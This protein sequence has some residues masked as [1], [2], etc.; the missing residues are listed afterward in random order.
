MSLEIGGDNA[1]NQNQK[2]TNQEQGQSTRPAAPQ[3]YSFFG[4][5]RSVMPVSRASGSEVI[6]LAL[7]KL[8]E[9][10]KRPGSAINRFT[11]NLHPLDASKETSIAQL[12]FSAIIVA[13]SSKENSASP[14]SYHTLILGASGPE[15]PPIVS[16]S[17]NGAP[18]ITIERPDTV[19]YNA[20]YQKAVE[21]LMRAQYPGRR[22]NPV[23]ATLVPRQFNWTDEEAVKVLATNAVMPTT[24][25][26]RMTEP[27][28]V[29]INFL[30]NPE[31]G[32]EPDAKFQAQI[33][34]NTPS[35]TDYLNLP[36]HSPV[37]IKLVA[38]ALK[39]NN[40]R[41]N[42]DANALPPQR[43][44]S[45]VRGFMDV[46]WAGQSSLSLGFNRRER[47]ESAHRVYGA[48][49]V[50]T[51]MEN[52]DHTT[53]AGQLLALV[54]AQA[55]LDDYT[56]LNYFR[57]RHLG[58][59]EKDYRDFGALNIEANIFDDEGGLGNPIDTSSSSF[60]DAKLFDA[61]SRMF[62]KQTSLALDV[63]DAGAD[64]WMN[65]VFAAA[66]NKNL[67]AQAAILSAASRLT[68]RAINQFYP[69]PDSP[70]VI[71]NERVLL[72]YWKNEKGERRDIREVDLVWIANRFGKKGI[73]EI[74][75]WSQTYNPNWD[76]ARS[77]AIRRD[78]LRQLLPGVVFIGEGQRVTFTAKFIRAL[79]Q[80]LA[81]QG[82]VARAN[83]PG[84][85]DVSDSRVSNID[86]SALLDPEGDSLFSRGSYNDRSNNYTGRS[87]GENRN[88]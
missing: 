88:W 35:T 10:L 68:N 78:I 15:L 82:F 87:Y 33:L 47:E 48:R 60:T 17:Q 59:E 76:E 7:E 86:Q 74:R 81:V 29:E 26:T 9:T 46:Q 6:G 16:N 1:Q 58:K 50:A 44:I 62:Y 5:N 71:R 64:T 69:N 31:E 56:W 51:A 23:S 53:T 77:L 84:A 75:E 73:K 24:N 3:A 52:E 40:D 38:Q 36:V 32:I 41:T 61:A 19:A 27:G 54:T 79:S 11:I 20:T 21:A 39:G 80:A 55:F 70:V 65:E 13:T 22:L 37:Q 85:M 42:L 34:L 63:S 66:A 49:F 43:L 28:Y 30:K 67:N 14:I 25:A 12:A 18:S 57:P 72:G 4:A 2:S 8:L 45:V 83:L